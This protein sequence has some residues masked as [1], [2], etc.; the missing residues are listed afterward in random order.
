MAGNV[1]SLCYNGQESDTTSYIF[2][3]SSVKRTDE[4]EK[5]SSS[6]YSLTA[7]QH[8]HSYDFWL[9][10]GSRCPAKIYKHWDRW[11]KGNAK[12]YQRIRKRVVVLIVADHRSADTPS[13]QAQRKTRLIVVI[14]Q[15]SRV[16]CIA[17]F[18]LQA[19]AL[20]EIV[21]HIMTTQCIN[22]RC[23][24]RAVFSSFIRR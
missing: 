20:Y 18:S 8:R 22:Q 13:F 16:A 5:A 1:L 15:N 6:S 17:K 24:T 4:V 3:V 14:G 23:R 21:K 9:I 2:R 10:C 7:T 19:R 12:T 11:Q